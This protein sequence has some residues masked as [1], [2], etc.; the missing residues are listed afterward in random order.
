MNCRRCGA[1]RSPRR[2]IPMNKGTTLLLTLIITT[3]LLLGC[4]LAEEAFEEKTF[5]ADAAQISQIRI[6]VR[7]RQIQVLP[8]ADGQI[9]IA[10]TQSGKEFYDIALSDGGVLTMTSATNKTWADFFGTKAPAVHRTIT[11]QVPSGVVDTLHLST[12]NEAI[13]LQPLEVLSDVSLTNN[14]GA[15]TFEGLSAGRAITLQGKNAPI[16]GSILGSYDD[17]AI[18]C[19]VKKGACNLPAH[20]PGGP[21]TL[22]VTQNNGDVE[23]GVGGKSTRRCRCQTP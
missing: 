4:S 17:F 2:R 5:T 3:L 11:L 18:T 6:D 10:Y 23:V 12:T 15:I 7:D 19:T 1:A 20:K 21:K 9:H 14:G 22:T 8:S 13:A 16:A